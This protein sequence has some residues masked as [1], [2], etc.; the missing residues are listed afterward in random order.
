[1]SSTMVLPME[2]YE[3]KILCVG[4]HTD[5][6]VGEEEAPRGTATVVGVSDDGYSVRYE[7]HGQRP[8]FES[9][10]T[11]GDWSKV[12]ERRS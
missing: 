12:S 5:L 10:V 6:F 2:L 4:A 9:L 8:S 7:W 11:V 3:D 1:M